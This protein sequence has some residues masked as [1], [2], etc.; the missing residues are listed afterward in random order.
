MLNLP[1]FEPISQ[2]GTGLLRV[3][4]D[5][6]RQLLRLVPRVIAL[7]PLVGQALEQVQGIGLAALAQEVPKPLGLCW[8]HR[9]Q[10]SEF[11]IRTIIARYQDDVHT[12]GRQFK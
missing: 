7:Q 10:V 1:V 5:R 8:R 6:A 4:H 11:R 12:T 2:R 3:V 9:T